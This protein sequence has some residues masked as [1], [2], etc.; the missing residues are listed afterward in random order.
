MFDRLAN[1]WRL[2]VS[3][4]RVLYTDKKLLIFPFLSGVAALLVILS[5]FIPIAVVAAAV[6][7]NNLFPPDSDGNP[8]VG[9]WVYPTL[10]AFYYCNYFVVIFFNSAL[11]SC[12]LMRFNGEQPSLGDGFRAAWARL[13]QIALWALVA[14]T[15]GLILKWIESNRR[16][17]RF[18]AAILG[19]AWTVVTYFV[20]PVIVVEK[21]NPFS[22]IGRS[23]SILRKTWGE[24]LIGNLGLGLIKFLLALPLIALIAI[25][26]FCIA[27]SQNASAL[28]W[29]G[30]AVFVLAG[31]YFL[32]FLAVASALGT[33]FQSA[34]YQYAAFN[35]V[36]E[37]FDGY[38]MEEAFVTRR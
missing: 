13:P 7:P 23:L 3:S 4:W 26:V 15:V 31:L 27:G 5:F 19:T 25:G 9:W 29:V 28:L 8:Q 22:A 32:V 14:A 35:S 6:G 1:S 21:L 18:V 2:A 38:A 34:L 37:G 33:I 17:G 36:P 20:V 24:A 11:V 10:F 12:A 30:V 16:V